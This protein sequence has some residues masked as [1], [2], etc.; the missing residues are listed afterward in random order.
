VAW[1]TENREGDDIT[2]TP[3]FI[4]NGTKQSNMSYADF[5]TL[6]DAELGS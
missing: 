6:I 2:S 1:E 4:I 5:K 3:S